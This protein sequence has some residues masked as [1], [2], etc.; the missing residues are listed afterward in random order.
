MYQVEADLLSTFDISDPNNLKIVDEIRLNSRIE[1]LITFGEVL[2]VGSGG[3]LIS[4]R[5]Q[6]NGIP[7]EDN[8]VPYMTFS[9]DQT[10]CDLLV[11]DDNLAFVALIDQNNPNQNC[12]RFTNNNIVNVFDIETL[13]SPTLL[14]SLMFSDLKDI[15]VADH[16]LFVSDGSSG[17]KIYDT[18]NPNDLSEIYNIEDFNTQ[19]VVVNNGMLIVAGSTELRQ[20][21]YADITNIIEVNRIEI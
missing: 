9:A 11:V 1:S 7:T 4:F 6:A 10:E 12:T 20:Y 16:L 19:D 2:F 14:S 21:D 17:F 5:I 18:T 13:S 15:A 3:S 8:V